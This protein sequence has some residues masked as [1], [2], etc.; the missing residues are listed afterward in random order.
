MRQKKYSGIY[1]R[2]CSSLAAIQTDE[3]KKWAFASEDNSAQVQIQEH[4]ITLTSLKV[5]KLGNYSHQCWMGS[6]DYF[7]LA[8]STND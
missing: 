3:I 1:F 6:N 8:L 4:R 7:A 2:I 5:C